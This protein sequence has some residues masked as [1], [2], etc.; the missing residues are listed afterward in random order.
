MYWKDSG[1]T[2]T[3]MRVGLLRVYSMLINAVE[4]G[5]LRRYVTV[6]ALKIR[7]SNFRQGG[8]TQ[9]IAI[10]MVTNFLPF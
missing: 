2:G 6:F 1:H 4:N 9:Q 7:H 10:L 8:N 5:R 3:D